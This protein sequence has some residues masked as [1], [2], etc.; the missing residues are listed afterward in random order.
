MPK[1]SIFARIT[2]F[3]SFTLVLLGQTATFPDEVATTSDLLAAANRA[4]STLSSTVNSST[5]TIPVT[6]GTTFVAYSIVTIENERIKICTVGGSS[7][8]ACSDGRGYDGSTAASHS[9]GAPVEARVSAYY[10]NKLAAEI[11][12]IESTLGA[13]LRNTPAILG[14]KVSTFY[15]FAAQTPGGTLTGVSTNSVTLTPCPYGVAGA[16]ANH[17]LYISGGVG[18]AESVL[19]TGGTC[20]SGAT[21]GTVIFTPVNSHSGAWTISSA[22]AGIQES[23]FVQTGATLKITPGTKTLRAAV[24]VAQEGARIVGASRDGTVISRTSGALFN[25]TAGSVDISNL[26]LQ[27]GA[28]PGSPASSGNIGIQTSGIRGRFHDLNVNLLYGGVLMSGGFHSL[29]ENIWGRNLSGYVGKAS[30]GVGPFFRTITY[31]TD[32]G[33]DVPAEAGIVINTEGAYINDVDIL[34]AASGILVEATTQ[35][36]TW[37]FIY[38]ARLDQNYSYGV[39]VI[40]NSAFSVTGVWMDNVWANSTG[41][42]IGTQSGATSTSGVGL[43]SAGTG[44]IFNVRFRNGQLFNNRNENAKILR[45]D[46]RLENNDIWGSNQGAGAAI[47]SIY[48]ESSRHVEII[49]GEIRASTPAFQQR[50]GIAAGPNSGLVDVRDVRINLSE[51]TFSSTTAIYNVAAT[52]ANVKNYGFNLGEDNVA[53]S[54]ASTTTVNLPNRSYFS[55][56][57]T[58]PIATMNYGWVGR[59]IFLTKSDTGTI[60]F[61]TGGNIAV[62]FTLTQNENAICDYAASKWICIK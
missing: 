8:T 30:D 41:M 37:T 29:F 9:A 43:Y 34:N 39:A 15:D 32:A 13:D 20:T 22:T 62:G 33:Y 11:A 52:P 28:A 44:N 10:H 42:G 38:D 21:T 60:T 61:G 14:E 45:G 7:L 58:N 46:A 56:T 55:F 51:G 12:A 31:D 25:V 27:G 57:G 3:F 1:R 53:F 49:G 17:Y 24:T 54:L 36:V 19:I 2:C 50:S 48:L 5:L 40:N 23:L 59:R 18:T 26:T 16:N 47:D 6:S 4:S 35:D